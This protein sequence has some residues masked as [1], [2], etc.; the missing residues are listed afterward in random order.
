MTIAPP[1]RINRPVFLIPLAVLAAAVLTSLWQREAFLAAEV[2]INDWVLTWFGP[3]FAL[4]G[5]AFL[6]LL[7]AV[8]LSPLGRTIIGG[9]KRSRCSAAGAGSR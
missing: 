9:P 2:A 8:A 6:A 5:V 3:A 7:A 1:R 4:A